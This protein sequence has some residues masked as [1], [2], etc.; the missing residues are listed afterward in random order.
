VRFAIW[1]LEFGF[2]DLEFL[3]LNAQQLNIELFKHF[4]RA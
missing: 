4:N 2:W 3:S 1:N